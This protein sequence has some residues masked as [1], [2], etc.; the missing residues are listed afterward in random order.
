VKPILYIAGPM[1]GLPELNYPAFFKAE[2]D[3]RAA[4]YRRILNPARAV[5]PTDSDWHIWMRSGIDM[6]LRSEGVALLPGHQIS[7]G[8]RLE[9]YVAQALG[10]PVHTLDEWL[11]G[12]AV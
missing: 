11:A 7:R 1:S 2:E 12:V 4:G 6:V 8:A 3:L 9:R 10:M 5:C